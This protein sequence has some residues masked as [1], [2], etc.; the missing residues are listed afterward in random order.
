MSQ[1]EEAQV[2]AVGTH[3]GAFF[4]VLQQTARTQ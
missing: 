1:P 2:D 3:R 4:R